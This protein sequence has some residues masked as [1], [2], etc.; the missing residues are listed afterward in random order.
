[1]GFSGSPVL[2]VGLDD[3]FARLAGR[4]R[5]VEPRPGD[6]SACWSAAMTLA[7]QR[8][9]LRL[10]VPEDARGGPGAG[11]AAWGLAAE[12]A[13]RLGCAVLA[14]PYP[15]ADGFARRKC[16]GRSENR[17][18]RRP[19]WQLRRCSSWPPTRW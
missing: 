4:F 14:M 8:C 11:V 5:R 1:M 18:G 19:A 12:L 10:P 15:V 3:L 9:L 6:V 17:G 2:G 16:G 7:E 13:G